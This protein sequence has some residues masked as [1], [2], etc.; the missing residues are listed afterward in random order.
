MI[1]LG[2]V[3]AKTAAVILAE[4]CYLGAGDQGVV[5]AK[6]AVLVPQ[7]DHEPR[8]KTWNKMVSFKTLRIDCNL[9]LPYML[10]YVNLAFFIGCSGCLISIPTW[11][12]DPTLGVFCQDLP[13]DPS[14]M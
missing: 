3:R 5:D 6:G 2:L 13:G 9:T 7:A 10:F 1:A 12:H 8:S 14:G 11:L 4:F